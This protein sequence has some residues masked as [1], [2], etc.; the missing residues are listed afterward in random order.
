M[1]FHTVLRLLVDACGHP[2]AP[3][4]EK[5]FAVVKAS[6]HSEWGFALP[7]RLIFQMLFYEPE[8]QGTLRRFVLKRIV[9]FKIP[10]AL[11]DW[12]RKCI[13]IAPKVGS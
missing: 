12:L 2:Q 8:I 4:F 5:L 6:V 11:R 10:S 3:I 7:R 9:E 13:V 1:G